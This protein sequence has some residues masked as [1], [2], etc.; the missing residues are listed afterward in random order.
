MK[1]IVA[2][3]KA[4]VT[5]QKQAKGIIAAVMKMKPVKNAEIIVCPPFPFLALLSSVIRRPS[6]VTLGAQDVF[7]ESEGA[8]TG[9]V[10][11]AML[12]DFGVSYVI[13]G[14]SERRHFGLETDEIVNRKT[15][16]ALKAGLRVIVCVGE[17][18]REDPRAIPEIVGMQIRSALEDVP[19]M[20]MRNLIV[21]YEPIWAIG[22]GI[23][24]TPNDTMSA[25]LYIRKVV[26]N[27]YGNKIGMTLK[28]L[29][30]GSVNTKN[31]AS[32]I[33]QSGIDGVLVGRAST[34]K[35]EFLGIIGV[36]DLKRI[37]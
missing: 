13:V 37:N 21:A 8:Y 7:W 17:K 34:D 9:A 27:L 6:F 24:D 16:M 29:Y 31:A 22:T 33:H 26:G 11:L 35:K 12:K 20:Y 1:L 28:V 4:Y 36:G 23:S 19:A 18:E 2:N 15:R 25:S 32:F 14:H 30:G 3:W 10:T 5:T